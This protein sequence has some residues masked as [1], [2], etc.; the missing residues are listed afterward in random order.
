MYSGEINYPVCILCIPNFAWDIV[1]VNGGLLKEHM[2][3][4]FILRQRMS[5][6]FI[7]ENFQSFSSFLNEVLIKKAIVSAEGHLT[8]PRFA[9]QRRYNNL[10]RSI[11]SYVNK[12]YS[13]FPYIIHLLVPSRKGKNLTN[14]HT[15]PCYLSPIRF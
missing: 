11:S 8:F 5:C 3:T 9:R 14:S 15:I 6:N 2:K 4:P 12:L 10:I 13:P 7:Y 1:F